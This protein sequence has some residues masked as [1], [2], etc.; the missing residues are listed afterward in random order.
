MINSTIAAISSGL[1]EAGISVIR[2]SGPDA[3]G[4]G[5]KVFRSVSG[6]KLADMSGYTCALGKAISNKCAIDECIATVFRAP[7]SYTGED[8][9]ELSCH[10]GIAVTRDI[11]R[12]VLEAG[13][14]PAQP[15]EFTKR[16]FLNGKMDLIEAESVMNL[17]SAK[18]SGEAQAALAVKEGY[19][20]K[21]VNEIKS[22]LMNFAAHLNAWADY[23]EEDIPA[24]EP[25]HLKKYLINA[26][27]RLNILLK[28]YDA[29]KLM[30][31]GINT[32]II[33]RPNV[34]K[35][36]LMNLLSGHDRSIV[37]DVPGTTRD[38]VEEQIQ[39][40][41]FRLNLIDTAGIH[42]TEDTVEKIG[43]ERAQRKL[44]TAQFVIFIADLSVPLS[45]DDE[46][47]YKMIPSDIPVCFIHNKSDRCIGS[48]MNDYDG[49]KEKYPDKNVLTT[50]CT[51]L[52]NE[53]SRVKNDLENLLGR[54]FIGRDFSYASDVV[55]YNERQRNL[56]EKTKT[57]MDEATNALNIGETL[58]AVTVLIE[59]A[60]G[61]LAELT[62]E[63]VTDEVVDRVF[64]NFCV[65][66]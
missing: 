2:I 35:S 61:Y 21:Q 62:G 52:K 4:I 63:S 57:I 33:G 55:S 48:N 17:I 50:I 65:G 12:A 43:V 59:E 32:V 16:A 58:D 40:G 41:D 3:I 54:Y 27:N 60:V 24:I 45:A 39:L 9:V 18:S 23:P 11:L 44:E 28:K 66:K 36:T 25:G 46:H 8:V 1:T 53:G 5:E 7:R 31:H 64:H 26:S 56:I 10:G 20:S 19:I 37:T 49:L 29:G 47:I 13:A 14:S 38:T 51:S 34:G 42:D 30:N 22:E 6:K 15:G